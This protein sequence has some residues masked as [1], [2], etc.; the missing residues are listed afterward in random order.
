VI[1]VAL[2]AQAVTLAIALGFLSYLRGLRRQHDRRVDT[3]LDRNDSLQDRLAHA[4]GRPWAKPPREDDGQVV[5][6]D[7]A[8]QLVEP[9]E[10]EWP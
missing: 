5:Q 3:L 6:I 1:Y 4:E 9:G 8:L 7:P 10:E 2:S